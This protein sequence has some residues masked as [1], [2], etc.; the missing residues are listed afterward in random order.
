MGSELMRR[1][2]WGEVGAGAETFAGSAEAVIP[3]STSTSVRPAGF[4]FDAA[5]E[6][7]RGPVGHPCGEDL[8]LGAPENGENCALDGLPSPAVRGETKTGGVGG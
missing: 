7:W 8:S 1:L 4:T 5:G 3:V 6:G 2:S